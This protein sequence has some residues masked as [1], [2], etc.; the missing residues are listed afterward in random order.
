MGVI[1]DDGLVSMVVAVSR[2]YARAISLLHSRLRITVEIKNK[3]LPG[4][5]IWEGGDPRYLYLEGIPSHYNLSIGD[6]IQTSPLSRLFPSG[7]TVGTISE[8]AVPP[9]RSTYEIKIR[10]QNDLRKTRQVYVIDHKHLEE[11]E[12]LEAK[13]ENE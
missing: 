13:T 3:E 6:T 11:I 1:E 7:I 5:L 9:G 4:A 8:F 10:L 12:A 2:H